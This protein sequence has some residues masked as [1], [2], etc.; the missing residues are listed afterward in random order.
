ML[1]WWL[2]FPSALHDSHLVWGTNFL[3]L[4]TQFFLFALCLFFFFTIWG[5]DFQIIMGWIIF[6][7]RQFVASFLGNH[8]WLWLYNISSLCDAV[9]QPFYARKCWMLLLIVTKSSSHNQFHVALPPFM[10]S[11]PLQPEPF[12]HAQWANLVFVAHVFW[13]HLHLVTIGSVPHDY[14]FFFWEAMYMYLCYLLA[15]ILGNSHTTYGFTPLYW[16]DKGHVIFFW[17]PS[18]IFFGGICYTSF[19]DLVSKNLVCDW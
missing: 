10:S 6:L 7:I 13:S 12:F 15:T 5:C 19:S 11:A 9:C 18:S 16:W 17:Q 3:H 1:L 2:H 4:L 14:E 8:W